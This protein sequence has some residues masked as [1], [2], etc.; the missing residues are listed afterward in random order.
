M[1][2]NS[3]R[4]C[5]IFNPA[6]DRSRSHQHIKWLN[7]ASH[8]RWNDPEIHIVG[9]N[10]DIAETAHHKSHS[11][12]VV[13]ACGGDG[14][15]HKVINGI[16]GTDTALG[17]LP[18]GSGN[19][20]AKTLRL[21][22]TPAECLHIIDCGY[23]KHIDLIRFEGDASGWCA[24]TIGFG[25]DGWANH[26]AHQNHKLKG[27]MLY[28]YGALKAA[29]RFKGSR[30]ILEQDGEV[31]QANY[32]MVTACN[33]MWE[34]GNF[35]VAPHASV[36]D[37]KMDVLKISTMPLAQI[38]AY[39]PRFRWGPSAHMK[40][41]SLTSCN[42]LRY[43]SNKAVAVHCDGEEL[44]TQIKDL[45]LFVSEKFLEVIVPEPY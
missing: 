15:I 39:L 20:F 35:L 4:I 23:R 3:T 42:Y 37:G 2:K 16:A 27:G 33:G 6:A 36:T 30:V 13:V 28:V 8:E 7:R 32:L 11:Y 25:L 22:K 5:F 44:G 38:L 12:D 43:S 40:G 31:Q 9:K 45:Q 1:L 21:K 19:D 14:T 41:V 34:G 29:F 18:I 17:V 26:F 10:Q 24:N